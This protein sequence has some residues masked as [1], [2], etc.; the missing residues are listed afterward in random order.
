LPIRWRLTIFNALSIGAILLLLGGAIFFLVRGALL[1]GVE[2]TVKNRAIS[3]ARTIQSGEPL[4][5]ED[6]ERLTL[7]GVFVIV[8]NGQGKIVYD[9]VSLKRQDDAQDSVWRRA[10]RTGEPANGTAEL[11]EEEP[12]Y[13]YAV[14]VSPPNSPARVVEAG[15]SYESTQETLETLGTAL[16]AG[17]GVVLLVAIAGA[18]FLARTALRPVDAVVSAAREMSETDLS[19]RLPVV[20]HGDE[21]G[22]LAT[23]IN[24]FLARNEAA[25]SRR[26]EALARQRSFASDASHELRTPLTAIRGHARMLDEWALDDVKTAR[27]SV[28]T[29]RQES[30]RM[31]DLVEALMALTRGDEGAPLNIGR[32]DFG[33]IAEE[34]VQIARVAANGKVSVEYLPP[35]KTIEA[36]FDRAQIRRAASILLDNAVKYTP[37]GGSVEMRVGEEDG[38]A[39]LE[40]SDTGVGIAEDQ[41]PLVFE[42][43]HRVDPSRTEGG[44]GLGLS[45][46]RQIA[47][48]HGGEIRVRSRPGEGSTF[49][50]LLPKNPG[51]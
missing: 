23:T 25:A 13:V 18:Y 40:V 47:E 51:S 31:W 7:D 19:R 22:R 2:N 3:A 45:I 5:Q 16:A 42:R 27:K 28:R 29:I 48:S 33:K 24:G 46:A 20:N 4:S 11:S 44:A 32:H 17:V 1:S 37:K 50:L 12:D 26:E 43:F 10:L 34:A 15:K 41:L 8:R 39:I 21:I 30:D 36:T 35:E 9:T 14:P 38:Q 6:V 49:T